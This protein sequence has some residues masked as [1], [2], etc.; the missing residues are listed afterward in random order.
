MNVRVNERKNEWISARI[1]EWMNEIYKVQLSS[2]CNTRNAPKWRLA[3]IGVNAKATSL[4]D[5]FIENPI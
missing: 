2:G 1:N 4:P 5:W 3:Y